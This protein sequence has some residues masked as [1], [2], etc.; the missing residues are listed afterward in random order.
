[1]LLKSNMDRFIGA[2]IAFTSGRKR[3]LKSNMD[4]F[5]GTNHQKTNTF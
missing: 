4:R 5:I 2:R 1:M 3:I